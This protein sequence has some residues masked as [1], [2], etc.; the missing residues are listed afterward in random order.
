MINIIIFSKDRAC[1]LEL[2]LRSMKIFFFEHKICKVSI[3][4]KYSDERFKAGY[5][6]V[7]YLHPEYYYVQE[8]GG[9]FKAQ[10]GSLMDEQYPLTMFLVDDIVFKDYFFIRSEEMKLFISQEDIACLSLR[11]CPRINYCY[12]EKRPTPPPVVSEEGK[13]RWP[14]L[15][16]DW[17]YP[18]SVDG[19]IYKTHK[20]IHMI[21]TMSYHNPNTF[22]GTW[23][24]FPPQDQPYMVCF[25]ESKIV[26]NP[27]N[28]VQTANANHCGGVSARFINEQFLSGKVI[29]LKPF[30]GLKNMAA[31]QEEDI[32][33]MK[34]T[35]FSVIEL[36]DLAEKFKIDYERVIGNS[37]RKTY[38]G[39][40]D[41][42]VF[43]PIKGRESFIAPC[44][45]YLKQS[46]LGSSY[47]IR[48]II[49]E[50]DAVPNNKERITSLGVDYIF[51]PLK[52][53]FSNNTF[54]K[55]LSYNVG[56]LTSPK[57]QW[58][59][60]HD[61]DILVEQ[62]YFKKLKVYL[63]KNP[64]WVQPY[65]KRRVLRISD[66]YTDKICLG[67][68]TDLSLIPPEH[69]TASNPGSPGGSIVIRSDVFEGVGG[70]D[71]ELFYG[72]A[73][74][75]DILWTKLEATSSITNAVRSCFDGGGGTF[76]DDPAIEVYHLSHLSV[77]GQNKEYIDMLLYR[78]S[79]H[80]YTHVDKMRYIEYKRE[81]WEEAKKLSL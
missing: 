43:I 56:Y 26:N 70:Y 37:I 14:G 54:A 36:I 67:N 42:N 10:V 46:A 51:I 76:A 28:K 49:I 33:F 30:V 48:I 7:K 21:R 71:P 4:Y 81:I 40:A 38:E 18:N 23:A 79:Y 17:G 59:I 63:D 31:H 57:V 68:I 25:K 45:T 11:M 15:L 77:V 27:I 62:D 80:S 65:T 41:I 6:S 12:T 3:L 8:I 32:T 66:T 35:D 64:K 55:S 72:Y 16:G 9:G 69:I 58:N 44:V 20:I 39:E 29:S 1:Q 13:W 73:P 53:S 19:C 22:E 5:N 34:V 60:F 50:N 75:D 78:R 61:I 52:D 74:E 24:H 47:K 2:L